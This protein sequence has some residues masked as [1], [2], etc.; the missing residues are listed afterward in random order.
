MLLDG[1]SYEQMTRHVND[2]EVRNLYDKYNDGYVAGR[3][4]VLNEIKERITMGW[5]CPICLRIYSPHVKTCW[6]HNDSENS[7]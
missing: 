7:I 1:I 4:S 2:N 3:E 6:Y 5:Q